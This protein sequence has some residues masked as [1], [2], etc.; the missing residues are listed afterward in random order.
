MSGYKQ[1]AD[2]FIEDIGVFNKNSDDLK[3]ILVAFQLW[4]TK[5]EDLTV[6]LCMDGNIERIDKFAKNLVMIDLINYCRGE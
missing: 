2:D 3:K 5:K 6:F 1:I 4:Q